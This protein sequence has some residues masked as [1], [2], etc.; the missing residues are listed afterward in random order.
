MRRGLPARFLALLLVCLFAACGVTAKKKLPTQP[1]NL[2]TATAADLQQVPGIGPSTAEKILQMR[3]SHGRF[4]S[5]SDIQAIHGIGPKRFEKMRRYQTVG[6]SPVAKAT[7]DHAPQATL[8][9]SHSASKPPAKSTGRAPTSGGTNS[10]K[11]KAAKQAPA[12]PEEPANDEEP[13]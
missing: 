3:K 6:K 12:R 2:N 1:I 10:S 7:G 4:H 8:E 11:A 9:K 5:V 13:E